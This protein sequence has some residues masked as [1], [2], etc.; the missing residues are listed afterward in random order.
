MESVYNKKFILKEYDNKNLTWK[1]YST[2]SIL[3]LTQLKSIINNLF[4]AINLTKK[5]FVD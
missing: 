5:S 4:L 3:S 1:K 2:M